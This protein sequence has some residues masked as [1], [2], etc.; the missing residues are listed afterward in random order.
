[1]R[2]ED[3]VP[4]PT[5][6]EP[7]RAVGYALEA[8]VAD[9]DDSITA[10]SD[11]VNVRLSAAPEPRIVIVGNGSGMDQQ[12]LLQGMKPAARPRSHWPQPHD[13]DRFFIY[14]AGWQ[15]LW[16]TLFR[17]IPRDE[18]SRLVRSRRIYQTTDRRWHR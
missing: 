9:I 2:D 12:A 8:A 5:T 4:D 14:R 6:M 16:E 10:G 7:M 1:M 11:P 15:V 3:V 13:L 18:L 17:I